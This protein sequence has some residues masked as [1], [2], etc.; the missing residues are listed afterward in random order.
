MRNICY[1]SCVRNDWR[2][3]IPI[4]KSI[5]IIERSNILY[6]NEVFK[7]YGLKGYQ[8]SYL[9]EINKHPGISQEQLT[10]DMHIDKSNVARG[11][12]SLSE[13]GYITRVQDTNDMRFILLY[14]TDEGIKLAQKISV[15][16]KKQRAYLLQDFEESDLLKLMEYLEKLK[17]RA[18]ELLEIEKKI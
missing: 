2:I 1:N 12:I 15:I 9:L 14:P 5:S 4:N 3:M 11:L 10:K 7:E 17:L 18:S 16:L 8:A 6:R 13:S